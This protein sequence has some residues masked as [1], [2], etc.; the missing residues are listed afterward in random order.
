MFI[1]AIIHTY[2][3]VVRITFLCSLTDICHRFS[4]QKVHLLK[5][6]LATVDSSE[7][8]NVALLFHDPILQASSGR[9]TSSPSVFSGVC[10]HQIGQVCLGGVEGGGSG[11]G[12]SGKYVHIST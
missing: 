7:Y 5:S 3:Y 9:R 6:E 8:K 4:T 1:N 11:A 12:I 2:Q 10:S